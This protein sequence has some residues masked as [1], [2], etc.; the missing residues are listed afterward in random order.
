MF[1]VGEDLYSPPETTRQRDDRGADTV[2]GAGLDRDATTVLRTRSG[3][4]GGDKWAHAHHQTVLY[5]HVVRRLQRPRRRRHQYSVDL[6]KRHGPD[7]H[8]H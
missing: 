1:T 6:E 7:R 5:L 3:G 2:V 8:D 4:R